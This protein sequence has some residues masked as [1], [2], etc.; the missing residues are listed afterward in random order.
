MLTRL[1]R[2]LARAEDHWL[3]DLVGV[4]LIFSIP[5]AVLFTSLILERLP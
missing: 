3:T 1:R 5:H 4:C 2:A